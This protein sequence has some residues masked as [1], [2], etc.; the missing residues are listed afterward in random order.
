M[1]H[2]PVQVMKIFPLRSRSW[3]C[4]VPQKEN[5]FKFQKLWLCP[6]SIQCLHVLLQQVLFSITF[7]HEERRLD[8]GRWKRW[9][10]GK[11]RTQ[12]SLKKSIPH[13][14]EIR[15]Q[16]LRYIVEA[17]KISFPSLMLYPSSKEFRSLYGEK[18]YGDNFHFVVQAFDWSSW[19][20]EVASHA[21]CI[22]ILGD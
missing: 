15:T 5:S 8:Y 18:R 12:S 4:S 13:G 1:E 17:Q 22:Q 14:Q 19:E 6:M 2:D 16:W 10:N 20:K 7:K 21:K 3:A 11:R 9:T